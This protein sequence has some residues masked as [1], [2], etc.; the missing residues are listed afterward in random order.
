MVKHDW[1][2]FFISMQLVN[3]I[4]TLCVIVETNGQPVPWETMNT[5]NTTD[6]IS[7]DDV[8]QSVQHS[9]IF[10]DA[11][12]FDE[13]INAEFNSDGKVISDS[14]FGDIPD[15]SIAPDENVS[16]TFAVDCQAPHVPDIDLMKIDRKLVEVRKCS[17]DTLPFISTACRLNQSSESLTEFGLI[18]QGNVIIHDNGLG[19]S[20]YSFDH[21][22]DPD[23]TQDDVFSLLTERISIALSGIPFVCIAVGSSGSGKT[24]T[25]TG[26]IVLNC[27]SD[28]DFGV[29]GRA[30]KYCLNKLDA[31]DRLIAT[32]MEISPIKN[33]DLLSGKCFTLSDVD[34]DDNLVSKVIKRDSDIHSFINCAKIDAPFLLC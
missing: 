33:V 4:L 18:R 1:S 11:I 17:H 34:V 6:Q 26:E 21:I 2:W 15:L 27:E 24:Y 3:S 5:N 30:M 10:V 8:I 20:K 29:L 31:N 23:D 9:E 22:L 19:T 12:C 13:N 14:S 28:G 32:A 7:R 25:M 16:P